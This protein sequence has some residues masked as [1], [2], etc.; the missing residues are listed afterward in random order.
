MGEEVS[1]EKESGERKEVNLFKKIPKEMR[2]NST[3]IHVK[4]QALE[5]R[6]SL[7]ESWGRKIR[8]KKG[9]VKVF[10]IVKGSIYGNRSSE[11]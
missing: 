11:L 2:E 6:L 1:T 8:E 3:K 7:S 9:T 4:K 10:E 5:G